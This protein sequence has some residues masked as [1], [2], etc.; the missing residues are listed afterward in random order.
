MIKTNFL[1][2]FVFAILEFLSIDL[3]AQSEITIQ[4]SLSASVV[5]A[6][7]RTNSYRSNVPVATIDEHVISD[8]KSTRLNS[9]HL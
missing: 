9:S 1:F 7:A 4:D 5:G 3:C 6:S 2:V 8:R